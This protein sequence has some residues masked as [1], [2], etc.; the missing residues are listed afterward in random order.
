MRTFEILRW[1]VN[2][3][4]AASFIVRR[5]ARQ[6]DLVQRPAGCGAGDAAA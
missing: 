6:V 1:L 5:P 3:T 4:W 2:S